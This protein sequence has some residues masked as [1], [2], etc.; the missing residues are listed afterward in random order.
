MAKIITVTANTAFD[1]FI[2]AIM[3]NHHIA[4]KSFSG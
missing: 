3:P 4:K 2:E 1:F